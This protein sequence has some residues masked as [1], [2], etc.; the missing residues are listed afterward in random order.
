M[1]Y[2]FGSGLVQFMEERGLITLISDL[3]GSVRVKKKQGSYFL[4]STLYAVCNF[5]IS[6]LPIKFNLPMV[7]EPV[8]WTSA[9]KPGQKPGNLSDLSGGYLSG[10]TGDI[11][12]RYRL[13]SSGNINNF[14]IDIGDNYEKRCSVMNKL[15]RQAFQINSDWLKFLFANENL[16]V[17]SGLL[18]PR[19]LAFMNIKEVSILLREFYMKD[20]V[21]KKLC[22]FTE[23]LNT[24][25]KNIQRSR[26][27]NLILNL[28]SAYDGYKFDLPAF[29]DFR[30]RIYRSGILHFH[31]RDLARSLIIFSDCNKSKG[32]MNKN[33]NTALAAAAFHYKSFVSV[34]EGREWIEKTHRRSE[35]ILSCTLWKLNAPFSSLLI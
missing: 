7:C 30:G 2:P 3:R 35:T 4:P 33:K 19:F 5:D 24:I 15:Q 32:D 27:E 34:N 12:D 28:A 10:L 29:L 20:E 14:Y 6:L 9:C 8:D 13:L 31:E 17:E 18:M 22:S 1:M 25:H 26:Y 16:F 23:L 11:Y 21:I